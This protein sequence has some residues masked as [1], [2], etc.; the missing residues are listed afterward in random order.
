MTAQNPGP[1]GE[2]TLERQIAV[3][4][5]S[6]VIVDR[7]R[8][9][10]QWDDESNWPREGEVRE[11]S[12]LLLQELGLELGALQSTL[13]AQFELRRVAE[14]KNTSETAVDWE[15]GWLAPGERSQMEWLTSPVQPQVPEISHVQP[16]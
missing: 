16:V 8:S 1:R 4:V 14:T 2:A 13:I 3:Y 6:P 11:Q 12:R 15:R 5:E 10:V 7:S 9:H